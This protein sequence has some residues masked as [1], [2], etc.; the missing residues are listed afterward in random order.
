MFVGVTTG[1]TVGDDDDGAGVD[2]KDGGKDGFLLGD[3]DGALVD[4]VLVDET[5]EGFVVGMLCVG[6]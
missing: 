1:D 5:E 4:G 3:F 2:P 6:D